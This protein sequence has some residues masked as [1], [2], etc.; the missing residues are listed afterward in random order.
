M[1]EYAQVETFVACDENTFAAVIPRFRQ[2]LESVQ[3]TSP[4]VLDWLSHLDWPSWEEGFSMDY[5][6]LLLQSQ[7]EVFPARP[8]LL[9]PVSEGE[10]RWAD[11]VELG[12]LFEAEPL[13]EA[14]FPFGPYDTPIVPYKVH[15]GNFIWRILEAFAAVF[16]G[17]GV[18]FT[19]ELQDSRVG[20]VVREGK[21]SFWLYSASSP[22]FDAAIIPVELAD[23]FRPI[24]ELFE[25]IRLLGAVG[26][27]AKGRFLALPWKASPPV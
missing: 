7:A 13:R 4:T 9:F 18:Y 8:Y 12:I 6:T 14:G 3:C 20:S 23:H 17:N 1:P 19:D 2:V 27:A 24:P 22:Q 21:G 11:W 5:P 10:E 26:V 16:L 15:A 25:Q